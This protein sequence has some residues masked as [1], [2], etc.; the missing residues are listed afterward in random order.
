MHK[1]GVNGA[2]GRMGQRVVRILSQLPSPPEVVSVDRAQAVTFSDCDVVIDF[3]LPAA[4]DA[5]LSTLEGTSAALVTGVTGRNEAQLA[6]I[7]ALASRRPVLQA[8]NFSLG[9]HV[10][11]HLVERATALLGTQYQV[12]IMETHHQ[13]KKDLP[14][15][16]AIFLGKTVADTRG[17]DF[18]LVY[19]DR[20]IKHLR[21]TAREIGVAG[22]RGG[23]VIGDHHVHFFGPRE[24]LELS[25]SAT[26]RDVFAEGAVSVAAWLS[27]QTPGCYAMSDFVR[28][29]LL[30]SNH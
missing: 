2:L 10:L 18:D 9:V 27:Q 26:D 5:L 28:A 24:R 15:G 13:H 23:A 7:E 12:E 14:S 25:H 11:G 1:V 21:Q 19:A 20:G 17:D 6:K 22:M 3:S 16:T 8:A 29:Q 4:T 30:G